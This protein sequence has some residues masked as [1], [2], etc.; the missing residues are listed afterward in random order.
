M[1]L[2]LRKQDTAKDFKKDNSMVRILLR[3]ITQHYEDNELK[4]AKVE[5]RRVVKSYLEDPARNE[6]SWIRMT[7]WK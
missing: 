1:D 2:V 5:A 7:Q 6:N 4:K 3:S